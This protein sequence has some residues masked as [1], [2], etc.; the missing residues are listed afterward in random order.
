MNIRI[1]VRNA[2]INRRSRNQTDS[3]PEKPNHSRS[4]FIRVEA[5]H[6]CELVNRKSGCFREKKLQGTEINRLES[7]NSQEN[8]KEVGKTKQVDI[9]ETQ[10]D[11][12][13]I[14]RNTEKKV[15]LEAVYRRGI[16]SKSRICTSR[17]YFK[18]GGRF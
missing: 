11:F 6:F 3:R 2:K 15:H 18:L 4:T 13:A 9:N 17:F 14:R 10:F 1:M 12:M 5:Q 7:E 8:Y 16:Q